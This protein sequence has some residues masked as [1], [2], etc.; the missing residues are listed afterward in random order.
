[1]NLS[2][3]G[4]VQRQK[5]EKRDQ[6]FQYA[7]HQYRAKHYDLAIEYYLAGIKLDPHSLIG[8]LD[9]G[10]S[11]E[12][13]G[14]WAQALAAL[15]RA[16]E[17]SPGNPTAQRR[18][19]RIAE[20]QQFFQEFSLSLPPLFAAS[21][22]MCPSACS[23]PPPQLLSVSDTRASP[24]VK[25]QSLSGYCRQG[26]GKTNYFQLEISPKLSVKPSELTDL[27]I[28]A[29]TEV[30]RLF[31]YSSRQTNKAPIRILVSPVEGY[32][33]D[34]KPSR[35]LKS[36]DPLMPGWAAAKY[37]DRTIFI[38]YDQQNRLMRT[39][40]LILLRHEWVHLMIDQLSAGN[41]PK[42]LDEGLA[43]AISRPMM[44]SERQYIMEETSGLIGDAK[45]GCTAAPFS[46]LDLLFEHPSNNRPRAGY[47]QARL[48]V[49]WLVEQSGWDS[50]F[51]SIQ[52]MGVLHFPPNDLILDYSRK[53][54]NQQIDSLL[55]QI[56]GDSP[57]QL[58]Y[59]FLQQ[60]YTT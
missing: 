24:L 55:T 28:S 42:W 23:T 26:K 50:I 34:A 20:E 31:Q 15:D 13:L 7:A 45:S 58:Y 8:Y 32:V 33:T 48:F 41:C 47:L 36:E 39:L 4:W 21:R 44:D 3:K 59:N 54:A 38:R 35:L 12:M 57:N 16:L 56:L 17:L 37:Q 18:Y 27:V 19:K 53:S 43:M 49:E 46:R 2:N 40:F 22:R 11:Y 9:L 14:C 30:D 25:S 29:T 10:K 5:E 1:M 51:E 60:Q 52:Q 6:Y